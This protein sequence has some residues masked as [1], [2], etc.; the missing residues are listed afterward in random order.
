MRT[1]KVSFYDAF[2][3]EFKTVEIKAA[4]VR[5]ALMQFYHDY[6]DGVDIVFDSIREVK[7][8]LTA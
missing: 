7:K 8:E 3:D 4:S 5:A 6:D 2:H 1:Y